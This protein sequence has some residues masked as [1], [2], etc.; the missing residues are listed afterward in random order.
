MNVLFSHTGT[1]NGENRLKYF[2]HRKFIHPEYELSTMRH[3]LEKH[4]HTY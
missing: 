3:F 2:A 4:M 1:D